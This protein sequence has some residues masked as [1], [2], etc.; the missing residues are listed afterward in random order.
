[1]LRRAQ[2]REE[3]GIDD[4]TMFMVSPHLLRLRLINDSLRYPL[5]YVHATRDYLRDAGELVLGSTTQAFALT[6]VAREVAA[7]VIDDFDTMLDKAADEGLLTTKA[8]TKLLS[9][10]RLTVSRWRTEFNMPVEERQTHQ[11]N[12]YMPKLIAVQAF[13]DTL[14]WEGT[15]IDEQ[16]NS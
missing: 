5:P 8:I 10:H 13:R 4:M 9:V 12:P 6:E 2:V 3:L 1:M 7:N 11:G 14:A 15:V 16:P